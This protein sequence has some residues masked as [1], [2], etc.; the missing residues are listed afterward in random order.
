MA[1]HGGHGGGHETHGHGGHEKHESG[2]NNTFELKDFLGVPLVVKFFRKTIAGSKELYALVKEMGTMVL[3]YSV[4]LLDSI[5]E[6]IRKFT[7]WGL[8]E[9]AGAK[10]GGHGH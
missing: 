8:L 5:G 4:D 1:D 3:S 7:S 9:S 10:A 2:G 6:Q